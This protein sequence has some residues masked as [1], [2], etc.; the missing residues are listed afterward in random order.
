MKIVPNSATCDVHVRIAGLRLN[1]CRIH[2]QLNDND[3][4][5]IANVL[6]TV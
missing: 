3:R 2:L 6:I 5:V 4:L 1:T